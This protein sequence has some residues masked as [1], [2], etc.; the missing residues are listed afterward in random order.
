M[1]LGHCENTFIYLFNFAI[2]YHFW[3]S[4]ITLHK[5]THYG[6]GKPAQREPIIPSHVLQCNKKQEKMYKMLF[7]KS[8]EI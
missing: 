5:H 6:L 8:N 1:S 2:N 7:N 3:T 4:T